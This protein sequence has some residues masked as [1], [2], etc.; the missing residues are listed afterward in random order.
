M[1]RRR[2]RGAAFEP[3][4][5]DEPVA[6]GPGD[7]AV[8]PGRP[9][10]ALAS[11]RWVLADPMA[12]VIALCAIL[13]VSFFFRVVDIKQPCQSPCSTP[14]SHTLIF[15]ESYYV[16]A[17]RVID[18]INPPVGATYHGAPLGDDPNA[19]HPQLAKL[20]IAGSIDIFGDN[21][22]GWRLPSILF[23]LIAL[24]GLYALVRAAGGSGWLAAGTAAVGSLDNLLLVHS[25]IAT[26]D[27]FAVT[28][29]IIA[30][31]LYLRRHPVWAGVALGVG[32]CMKEVAIYMLAVIVVFELLR[33]L[34]ATFVEPVGSA[35][36]KDWVRQ[37][38]RP[39]AI[40]I[41]STAVVF[42]VLLWFLDVLVPAY[43]TGT[44]ITYGG[45]PFAHF[46]HMVKYATQ[47]TESGKSGISS[48][49]WEWLLNQKAIPYAKTAEN[50]SSG[51]HII[52]THPIYFFQGL[53]NPFI[54]FLAI[55]ALFACLSI[56]WRSGDRVALIGA[57]WFLG[58]F[59][60]SAFESVA[61]DRV[62]YIYYMLIVVPA[63]YVLLARVFG[64]RRMPRAATIGWAVML[65]YGFADLFPIRKL[66]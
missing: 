64:D 9:Q 21:P 17:A 13:V 30:A 8:G 38:I 43:D 2:S 27:I 35:A 34:R 37:N 66:L 44:H 45:D 24:I 25:R 60:P 20:I 58:T 14:A 3:A 11:A 7:L 4:A 56:W 51:G 63:I 54:I 12:P 61:F 5:T 18:H 16:N 26:L 29:M 15:D 28:M 33:W 39:A 23:G 65:I 53:I 10:G 6:Q 41:G 52:A 55:P 62:N 42:L 40:A 1:S 57:A 36:A 22:Y 47:L 19:E 50:V 46:F 48:T 31:T 49:P 59:I 32:M